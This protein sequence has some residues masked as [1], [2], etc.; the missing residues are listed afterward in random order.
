MA[1]NVERRDRSDGEALPTATSVRGDSEGEQGIN[2]VH[3]ST[4]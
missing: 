4:R 1:L 2:F 3:V